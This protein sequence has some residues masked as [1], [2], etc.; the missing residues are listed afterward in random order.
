L[1]RDLKEVKLRDSFVTM[2]QTADFR[3]CND[4]QSLGFLVPLEHPQ[5]VTQGDVFSLQCSLAAKAGEK[6]TE[7]RAEVFRSPNP[8]RGYFSGE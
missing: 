4:G 3:K 2:V 5:L 1:T 8:M 7:R 6:L